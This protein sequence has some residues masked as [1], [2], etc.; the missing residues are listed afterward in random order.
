MKTLDLK[1]KTAVVTGGA[2]QI[3]RGIVRGLAQ[4]G[5]NVAITYFTQKDFAESLKKEIETDWGIRA[6]ACRADVTDLESVKAMKKHINDTLGDVDII[7]NNAVVEY[8]WKSVLE[9]S[10]EDFYSQY[11]S[12]VLQAVLM[13]KAF[14]PDMIGR[15][16]GRVI[17]INTGCAMQMLPYQSAYVSGKRGMDGVCKVLA[18]E[19]GEYGITVNQVAPGWTITDNC[20]ETDGTE[21]NTMQ[22]FPYIESVPLRRRGTE[23]DIVN[24]VCFLASDLA[25]FIT[26][27]Y[28]PVTGGNV[29]PCI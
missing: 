24:A 9:Q 18:R 28:L 29:M 17:A 14:V 21:A 8:E 20:R 22:D 19:V 3:G 10:V 13:A 5:A 15:R 1:G 2:S 11:Q 16:Y 7:V 27:V 25:G 26:G 23:V 12:C 4:C 6:T